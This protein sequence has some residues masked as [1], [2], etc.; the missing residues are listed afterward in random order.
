M[1]SFGVLVCAADARE[2]EAPFPQPVQTGHGT[3][4]PCEMLLHAW[5]HIFCALCTASCAFFQYNSL[6]ASP[7]NSDTS[8]FFLS[9]NLQT[10]AM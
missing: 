7:S 6:A 2:E 9:I 4:C 3:L 10:Q 8:S 1:V 5:P